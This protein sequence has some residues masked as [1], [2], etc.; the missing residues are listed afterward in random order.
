[1][2]NA[3]VRCCVVMRVLL[4]RI[5]CSEIATRA[6]FLRFSDSPS[7]FGERVESAVPLDLASGVQLRLDNESQDDLG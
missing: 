2:E 5:Q 1:M 4:A 7:C 6:K 3:F